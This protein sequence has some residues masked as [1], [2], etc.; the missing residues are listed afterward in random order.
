MMLYYYFQKHL[1]KTGEH[2]DKAVAMRFNFF[3]EACSLERKETQARERFSINDLCDEVYHN[4]RDHSALES[5]GYGMALQGLHKGAA[6]KL[7][8]RAKDWLSAFQGAFIVWCIQ[9]TL[10]YLISHH[11]L[12]NFDENGDKVFISVM[13]TSMTKFVARFIG[14]MLMHW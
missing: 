11:M 7:D 9:M 12:F 10:L 6:L 4:N 8:L 1:F 3:L 2:N 13:A 14:V 5:D